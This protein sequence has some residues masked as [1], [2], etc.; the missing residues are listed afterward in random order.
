M[1]EI[2]VRELVKFIM[3]KIGIVIITTMLFL[4]GGIVYVKFL[5]TP[6]Y[7]S[8]TTLILVSEN[9]TNESSTNIQSDVTL[10]KNLVGTYSE[11]VKSRT[12]LNE[13]K[14]KLNLE[15]TTDSLSSKI[16]VSSVENTEI[17]KIV[18]SDSDNKKA[19]EIA[20]KTAEVFKGEVQRI[21]NLTNVSIVDKAYLQKTPYNIN[22]PKQV[23]ISG[24]IGIVVGLGIVFMI[25][26][27]DTTIKSAEDI[28]EKLGL[29]V[30]GK[31]TLIENKRK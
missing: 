23:A 3:S 11:I 26:Y 30:L 16:K 6:M 25:F 5:L 4:I 24:V 9:Q 28:E 12:V 14:R 20:N 7:H 29:T 27:F 13:V 22:L 8:S 18:V 2:N 17:I 21:Y 10:N 19:M 15:E 1:E 31:V